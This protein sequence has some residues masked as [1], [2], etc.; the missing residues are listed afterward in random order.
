[1]R[2]YTGF[3]IFRGSFVPRCSAGF[4]KAVEISGLNPVKTGFCLL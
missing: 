2:F 4:L 1:M 3:A